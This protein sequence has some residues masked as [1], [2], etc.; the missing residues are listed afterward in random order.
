M[1]SLAKINDLNLELSSIKF[2]KLKNNY[3][4]NLFLNKPDISNEVLN[5]SK[6]N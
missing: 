3:L 2:N 1:S 4:L 6:E 5:E